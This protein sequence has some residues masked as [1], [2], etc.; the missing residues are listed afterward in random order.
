MGGLSCAVKL[1]ILGDSRT[2]T[3]ALALLFVMKRSVAPLSFALTRGAAG[4][5]SVLPAAGT[6]QNQLTAESAGTHLILVPGTVAV[7]A[8]WTEP[9][10]GVFNNDRCLIGVWPADEAK[11]L[12]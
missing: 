1:D 6:G 11:M 5:V 3:G 8:V 4:R 2:P 7:P 12:T 10:K 9:V